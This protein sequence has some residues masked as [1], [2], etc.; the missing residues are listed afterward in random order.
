MLITLLLIALL[1]L[2]LHY[3]YRFI[4]RWDFLGR[5]SGR[6]VALAY[7]YTYGPDAE[8]LDYVLMRQLQ[9]LILSLLREVWAALRDDLL[10]YLID[11]WFRR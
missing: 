9:Q 1:A 2:I 10:R 6:V 7:R 5:E 4:R 3:P 8:H 11:W